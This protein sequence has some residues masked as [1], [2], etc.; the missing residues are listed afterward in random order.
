VAGDALGEFLAYPLHHRLAQP[1]AQLLRQGCKRISCLA[2]AISQ[3]RLAARRL[4]VG[5]T[6]FAAARL[7][8]FAPA[9]VTALRGA[10]LSVSQQS[11]SSA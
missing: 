4:E 11:S 5:P 7:V 8:A 3:P 1:L 10:T 9:H 2:D 6:F